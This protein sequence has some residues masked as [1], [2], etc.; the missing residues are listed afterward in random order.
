MRKRQR[1]GEDS[2]EVEAGTFLTALLE[3]VEAEANVGS[4]SLSFVKSLRVPRGLD[5]RI[6]AIRVGDLR[7]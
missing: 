2:S 1:D 4:C 6:L 5:S 3:S 7:R